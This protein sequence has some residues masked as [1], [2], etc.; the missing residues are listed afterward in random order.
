LFK[1][2]QKIVSR[3]N[4]ISLGCEVTRILPL[5]HKTAIK[6]CLK[7]LLSCHCHWELLPQRSVWRRSK[8][9]S[10]LRPVF[11]PRFY[12]SLQFNLLGKQLKTYHTTA[13]PKILTNRAFYCVLKVQSANKPPQKE[14]TC[15]LA[16]AT[17]ASAR[18]PP[19]PTSSQRT[20]PATQHALHR[21]SH[22]PGP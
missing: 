14:Q 15:P 1:K 11:F 8:P 22:G 10:L 9:W 20:R 3:E 4:T 2:A 18:P 13:I 17:Q 19:Q 7:V 6:S 21:S 16:K 12:S 5:E